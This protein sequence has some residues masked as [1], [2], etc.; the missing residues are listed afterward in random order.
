MELQHLSVPHYYHPKEFGA[1]TRAELHAFSDASQDAIRAAVYL[2]QFNKAN[3]MSKS[4]VY[5]QAKLSPINPT[6]IPRL[7]L[8]GAVLAVQGAQKV[9]KE[10][11]VKISEVTY[12]TD[13]KVVL[14]TSQTK[15]ANF[16]SMWPTEYS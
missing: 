16:T 12:C 2:R 5:G 10:L 13:S 11:D 6:S 3:E 14:G 9:I 15:A 4:L 7:K 8:C 1:M